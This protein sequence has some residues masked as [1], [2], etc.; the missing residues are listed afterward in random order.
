[1]TSKERIYNILNF[2]T[3][4]RIG[5]HDVFL[6]STIESWRRDGLPADRSAEDYFDFDIELFDIE[7]LLSG[8]IPEDRDNEKFRIISFTEPFQRLCDIFGREEILRR[9]A[10]YP[11]RLKAELIRE[12]DHIINSLHSVL[13]KDIRFDG[14]WAWGDLA[15]NK[16][17]F[18]SA[19]SYKKR[20]LP[21]HKKIFQFLDS[22]DLF[23]L[24]HSDGMIS[25][26]I[27]YLVETGVRA[28]HPLEENSGMDLDKLLRLYKK[29]I[30]F[31]GSMNIERL[32]QD[33][34]RLKIKIEMLKNASFYIYQADY[35]IMPNV[36]FE[37]YSLALGVIKES[38]R[39]NR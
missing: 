13:E 36:S 11:E 25:D 9:F 27:P 35:P 14:A 29:D 38:G 10:L 37:D 17:L 24:F 18:F 8:N 26:L 7:D 21:L 34:K 32:V 3:P 23:I 20:L 22:R 39:Y 33:K 30:V 5:I 1:M 6:D 4:D 28:F 31:M 2:K 12:T 19:S 15:Y 16:G